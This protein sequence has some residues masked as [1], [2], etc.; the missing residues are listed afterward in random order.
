MEFFNHQ[1]SVFVLASLILTITPGVDTFLVMR[2]VLRGGRKDGVYTSLGACTGLFVHAT[3]SACGIS[4]MLIHSTVVF[5]AVKTVGALYLIWLG[6]SCIQN[7]VKNKK[8]IQFL[9][10]NP[11]FEQVSFRRLFREGF[12]SNVLN[13]KPAIFYLA[14]LPQFIGPS[15]PV[16]FKSM[17]LAS[18]QF[19]IGIIWL[20]LLSCLFFRIQSYLTA[21]STKKVLGT[22]SGGVL[23][24]FGIKLGLESY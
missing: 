16:F 14:F 11:E 9:Q 24:A 20:T 12:L 18:V 10:S 2:N 15:D 5:N 1:L 3:L 8:T 6:L 23:V 21:G 4:V 13:P 19:G 17:L 7:E 22:L